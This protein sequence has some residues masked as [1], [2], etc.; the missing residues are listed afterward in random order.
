M[1]ISADLTSEELEVFNQ[2]KEANGFESS[3]KA[4]KEWIKD[5]RFNQEKKEEIK[6]IEKSE[7]EKLLDKLKD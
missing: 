4:I 5:L 3:Y 6:E 7:T 1:K 2:Y